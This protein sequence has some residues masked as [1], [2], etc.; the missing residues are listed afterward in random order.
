MSHH[1]ADPVIVVED[2][3]VQDDYT[4]SDTAIY[5]DEEEGMTSST[6]EVMISWRYTNMFY[7]YYY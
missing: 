5:A 3:T 1:P 2:S 4:D 7:Y 6:S